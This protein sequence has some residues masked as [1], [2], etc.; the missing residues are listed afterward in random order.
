VVRQ[1]GIELMPEDERLLSD[2]PRPQLAG[3]IDAVAASKASR[4]AF[5]RTVTTAAG[6]VTG[7]GVAAGAYAFLQIPRFGQKPDVPLGA[8]RGL[9]ISDQVV[10]PR[11]PEEIAAAIH[12]GADDLARG[13]WSVG[14]RAVTLQECLEV[15]LTIAKDGQ[16]EDVFVVSGPPERDST[17]RTVVQQL[18]RTRFWAAAGRT[19]CSVLLCG[20]PE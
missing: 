12:A 11:S 3:M 17:T 14:P 18:R 20:L 13:T 15:Q 1:R 10:G 19:V 9:I 4:R 16:V 7:I 2:V 5:L 6:V 8:F